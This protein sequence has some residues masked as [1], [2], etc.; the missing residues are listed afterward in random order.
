MEEYDEADC[1][2]TLVDEW[3][4]HLA[5]VNEML[6]EIVNP[7]AG[8][9]LLEIDTGTGEVAL[10]LSEKLAGYAVVVATD[11]A[12]ARLQV[13]QRRAAAKGLR[14]IE[15]F[16][17]LAHELSLPNDYFDKALCQ[18]G[19]S[20]FKDPISGLQEIRRVLKPGGYL[21]FTVWSASA[22]APSVIWASEMMK[23]T[24]ERQDNVP[25]LHVTSLGR[26][27]VID[28]T[29][30]QAG[31]SVFSIEAQCLNIS[32]SSYQH[33]WRTLQDCQF[34]GPQLRQHGNAAVAEKISTFAEHFHGKDSLVVPHE[35]FLVVARKQ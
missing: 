26:P 14:N 13:A 17:M 1:I 11:S 28:Q 5:P 3:L 2:G 31:W 16:R 22:D 18:F 29:L 7:Q 12:R 25:I 9:K 35:Y 4:A 32:F 34:T 19:V 15:F 6:L 21:V 20:L 10:A 27:E 23:Q 33:L 30:Q 24:A 8:E